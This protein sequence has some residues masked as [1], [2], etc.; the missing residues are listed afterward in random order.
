MKFF[1]VSSGF[2]SMDAEDEEE[3]E[4]FSST[5]R[6]AQRSLGSGTGSGMYSMSMPV[7]NRDYY[8]TGSLKTGSTGIGGL[9][10]TSS[11]VDDSVSF[12]LNR[13]DASSTRA[14]S[15]YG[16][17]STHTKPEDYH[18]TKTSDQVRI[19]YTHKDNYNNYKDKPRTNPPFGDPVNTDR[20]KVS[21][22]ELLDNNRSGSSYSRSSMRNSSPPNMPRR[23]LVSAMEQGIAGHEVSSEEKEKETTTTTSRKKKKKKKNKGRRINRILFRQKNII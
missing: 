1:Q 15:S 14:R 22:G 6:S 17:Y 5:H 10:R 18:T 13:V 11:N 9:P 3:Y 7:R 19:Q 16:T 2:T 12:P 21:V 20:V 4:E 23:E 8:R